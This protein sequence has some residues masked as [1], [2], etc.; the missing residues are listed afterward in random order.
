MFLTNTLTGKK[1]I[2]KP[3]KAGKVGL[4][5]CGPT[6][7]NY[8][9]IGN[10]RTYIFNDILRKSLLYLGFKLTQVMNL[11]DVD[12]KTIK[13]SQKANLGLVEYTS[14]YTTAFREDLATLNIEEPDIWAKAT[15]HVPEM[16]ALISALLKKGVAYKSEDG[17][18][19]DISKFPKYGQLSKQKLSDLKHGA[20]VAADT[21]EKETAGDFAL[22]KFWKE[23]DGE[24]FWDPKDFGAG[25]ELKKGRP[26]WHI[27]CS[28]M[29]TKYL[30]QP[31]DIHTGGEDLIFPHHEN[32]IAQSEA[33]Y[34][35]PFA[36]YFVHAGMIMVDGK[37]MSK[38]L[39]NYY[40]LRDLIQ[41]GYDPMAFRLLCLMSHYRSPLNFTFK[42]LDATAET[43][44]SIK[45]FMW[46]LDQVSAERDANPALEKLLEKA[47]EDFKTY[48]EDD[49]QIPKALASIFT[50][51]G[52]INKLLDKSEL[53]T[54]DV[55]NI[56]SAI[57]DWDKIIGI[58][59][60][61]KQETPPKEIAELVEKR[62][63]ARAKKDFKQADDLRQQIEKQGWHIKDTPFGPSATK[64]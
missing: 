38:S 30:G 61:L 27:E 58:F 25:A 48:I 37:K 26:G 50:L 21:Y 19:F 42:E 7:Y 47:S 36:K 62:E 16:I 52:E 39:G 17:I 55:E 6:V 64:Y 40:T 4:Y 43:L 9:H 35:K 2:F 13:G 3:L 33:A 45:D 14:Y 34:E 12:D 56:Y 8:A 15:E 5:S 53:A 63:K 41:K 1:E 18:Y 60:R 23:E 44:R 57:W 10:M 20:R 54:T 31:F 49:L 29:S 28:A 24:V 22:W 11:T 59:G 32:E 46:R 51:I